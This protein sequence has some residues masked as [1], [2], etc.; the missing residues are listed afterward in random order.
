MDRSGRP[1]TVT[2]E[3]EA[4]GAD[5]EAE[6]GEVE[7]AAG[8][9]GA[10]VLTAAAGGGSDVLTPAGASAGSGGLT[11]AEERLWLP[12]YTM[13]VE[14]WR[15]LSRKLQT[16]AGLS[17]PDLTV[18]SALHGAPEQRLR[19]SQLGEF[20]DYEKSRLSRHVDRMAARG[21]VRREPQPGARGGVV[22]L[23][24][25]GRGALDRA[26]PIR[27]AHLRSVLFDA[28]SAEQTAQLE[29]ISTTVSA[30]LGLVPSP[31]RV[32]DCG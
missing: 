4:A 16:E 29:Q 27:A 19:P 2:G 6:T 13:Q 18:L 11:P 10:E 17:E 25:A 14:L 22:V 3:L 8:D 30:H 9:H 5:P 26:L 31:A 1:G 15:R 23:T 21:L 24:D 20:I 12:F 32:P 28:L 7:S